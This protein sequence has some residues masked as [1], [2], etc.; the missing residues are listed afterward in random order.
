ML[1]FVT[2]GGRTETVY[3]DDQMMAGCIFILKSI[4]E[5]KGCGPLIIIGKR[6]PLIKDMHEDDM[7]IPTNIILNVLA[8]EGLIKKNT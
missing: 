7:L 4:A 2:G 8:K 3:T 6:E 1:F 5:K